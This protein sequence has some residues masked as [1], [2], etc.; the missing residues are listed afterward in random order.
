L[1]SEKVA[2][3]QQARRSGHRVEVTGLRR[4]S[5]ITFANPDGTFTG[6]LSSGPER[7]KTAQGWRDLDP[8]LAR[9][10]GGVHPKV[11]VGALRLSAG[12]DRALLRASLPG[13]RRL[14]L[15]WPGVLPSPTLQGNTATYPNV[16]AGGDLL[17]QALPGGFELSL[18]LRQ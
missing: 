1:R 11:A 17:V 14:G 16:V 7:V 6:H 2:A 12:G 3:L 10:A 5:S 8:T 13:G 9:D 18:V 15:D 4:E